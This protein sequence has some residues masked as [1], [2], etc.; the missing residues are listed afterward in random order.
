[1]RKIM[2]EFGEVIMLIA[3]GGIIVAVFATGI[4]QMSW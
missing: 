3:M 4:S 1:M 2:E